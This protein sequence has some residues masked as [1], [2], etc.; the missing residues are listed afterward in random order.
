MQN[1]NDRERWHREQATYEE[2]GKEI[3]NKISSMLRRKGISARVSYRVKEADSLMKKMAR[4]RKE[5]ESITD[6]VGVRIVAHFKEELR[7]ID[8][9]IGDTYKSYIRK[10]E[11]MSEEQRDNIFGYQ[12]IHYDFCKII[13]EKEFYCE[14][15]LRT[16]CQD[17]WSELSHAIAYKN[18]IEIPVNINREINALSAVFELADNQ[19][20]LIQTLIAELP[21]TYS[22][23]VLNYLE[24]FFY[25]N[26]SDTYDKELSGYLLKGIAALYSSDS[27]IQALQNFIEKNEEKVMRVVADYRDNF[28]FT[29]P[30]IV[31]IL[32]RLE[33]SKYTF[34]DYW[35]KLYPVDEL[36]AIANAWG[37]SLE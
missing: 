14:V 15:Q 11:D 23:S 26:I 29:Q 18:E 33:N 19:F 16:I 24:K 35:V 4:K 28:F 36:E 34:K 27:P 31:F 22:V 20:Q 21:D 10:R 17:N 1:I 25:S 13:D 9:L 3:S 37:T 2:L 6:K 30:E 5:Y 8:S 12:A 7:A 32:E